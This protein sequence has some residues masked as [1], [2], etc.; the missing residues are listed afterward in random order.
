VILQSLEGFSLKEMATI[1]DLDSYKEVFAKWESHLH[2]LYCKPSLLAMFFGWF[3]V[4]WGMHLFDGQ[5]DL[6][7]L[8]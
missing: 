8:Q 2:A 1:Q 5:Q 4:V 6:V 3:N 7:K